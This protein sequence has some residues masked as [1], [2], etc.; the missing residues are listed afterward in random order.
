[1]LENHSKLTTL[2]NVHISDYPCFFCFVLF[3][4]CVCVR[5][6]F[7]LEC[8]SRSVALVP[9]PTQL[10]I[11]IS[12]SVL[13]ATESW[14]GPGNEATRS[15]QC[16]KPQCNKRPLDCIERVVCVVAQLKATV[17]SATSGLHRRSLLLTLKLQD[18]RQASVA[19]VV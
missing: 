4:A 5:F 6:F 8:S 11:T 19:S 15:V 12:I 7:F 2:H 13:Q 10:F 1:M 17:Q 9:G 16:L 3:F 18:S 14:V